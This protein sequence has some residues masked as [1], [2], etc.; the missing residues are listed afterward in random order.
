MAPV[1][2]RR[3]QRRRTCC[4]RHD[5]RVVLVLI[6]LLL[7]LLTGNHLSLLSQA[8]RESL[9]IVTN[10]EAFGTATSYQRLL[11][12][13]SSPSSQLQSQS[14]SS[15]S[16]I[17]PW[18]EILW[19]D[20]H[21]LAHRLMLDRYIHN[22]SNPLCDILKA[23][24]WD[25]SQSTTSTSTTISQTATTNTPILLNITVSCRELFENTPSGTG[26][27]ISMVYAMRLA[28]ASLPNVRLV[29]HCTD[30]LNGRTDY[31]LPW[32]SGSFFHS[33]SESTTTTTSYESPKLSSQHDT[34]VHPTANKVKDPTIDQ[35]CRGFYYGG[36]PIGHLLPA[37]RYELRRMAI[38][39]VGAPPTNQPAQE[40]VR[41]YG[42]NNNNNNNDNRRSSR[43]LPPSGGILQLPPPTSSSS[44]SGTPLIP[45]V[46]L[47]DVVI[48]FRCGDLMVSYDPSFAFLN[49]PSF[50]NRIDPDTP[51]I[52]IVTQPFGNTPSALNGAT[53]TTTAAQATLRSLDKGRVKQERCRIVVLD[54]VDYLQTRFP[55]ARITVH[56]NGPQ[57]SIALAFARMILANQTMT[58][59]SSFGVF[60]IVAAFGRGYI[61]APNFDKAPNDWLLDRSLQ[62]DLEG[63]VELIMDDPGSRIMVKDMRSMWSQGQDK[64]L[65]W[66]RNETL[67]LAAA[68]GDDENH[69]AVQ[70][71]DNNN[72]GNIIERRPHPYRGAQDV[73]GA[74]YVHNATAHLGPFSILPRGEK[75]DTNS[76]CAAPDPADLGEVA[77]QRIRQTRLQKET[78]HPQH[79][80]QQER[81]GREDVRVFCA[82]YTHASPDAIVRTD[83]ILETWGRRCDGLLLA[84][85]Q[86]LPEHH[87]VHILHGSRFEGHYSGMWQRVRAIL[88]Y[89]HANFIDDFDY[90]YI[91]GDDTFGLVDQLKDFVSSVTTTPE[92]AFTTGFW[93][94]CFPELQRY[95]C[96][97]RDDFYYLGGGSGYAL[98]RGA[99]RKFVEDGA[100]DRCRKGHDNSMEDVNVAWCFWHEL[101]VK[102]HDSR[103]ASGAQRFHQLSALQQASLQQ[104]LDVPPLASSLQ[105]E[106]IDHKGDDFFNIV[107]QAIAF[108]NRKYGF[109]PRFGLDR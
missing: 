37:M 7:V 14:Q 43:L 34:T 19:N 67:V 59:V 109:P 4:C 54:F 52:G 36:A 28:V 2:E 104:E 17:I 81:R 102:G 89:L 79:P 106:E 107:R 86:T 57:E 100:L 48:H 105:Q 31:V 1:M 60:P 77:L 91:C 73:H 97:N 20:T 27:W 39:L 47:D 78:Q 99:L 72:N 32:I 96:T 87:H 11:S 15:S 75:E 26:N 29:F 9:S 23:E 8:T 84:S 65:A 53:T 38:A 30:E 92:Q 68:E 108:Q 64:V 24:G 51:S 50:A 88:A 21:E 35:V 95:A 10:N 40:F 62:A 18:K 46:Q 93:M 12:T 56:N 49:F 33:P 13:L 69:S 66:F 61:A 58:A 74:P 6:A 76:V 45:N 83:A 44:S 42:D 94:P 41:Q 55:Q 80:Q 5:G 63:K 101:H 82:I 71:T 103:D 90:F 3:K 25:L 85:T 98:S 22:H 70:V 16:H